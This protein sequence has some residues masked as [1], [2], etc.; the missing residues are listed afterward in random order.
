MSKPWTTDTFISKLTDIYGDVFDTSHTHYTNTRSPVSVIC[1]IHGSFTRNA[2]SLLNGAGC[3]LCNI[4]WTNYVHSR[5]MTTAEFIEKASNKHNGF[6]S[7]TDTVYLNSRGDVKI[8]CPIHGIFTQQAGG[9]LEGYGC[10]KC[11]DKKH[12]EYRPWLVDTYF[13]KFPDKK[14]LPATLYLLYN[15]DEDFYKVGITTKMNVEDR[16]KYMSHYKFIIV[17][18]ISTTYYNAWYEEQRILTEYA[19]FKYKPKKRFGGWG[20]C[21][22]YPVDIRNGRLQRPLE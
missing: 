14:D 16:V 19:S 15:E 1:K 4:K 8:T 9:H 6:Y 7:Y 20:E 5:R 3:P 12:G 21:L 11:G 22:R 18:T 17:D 13:T 2:R 10:R